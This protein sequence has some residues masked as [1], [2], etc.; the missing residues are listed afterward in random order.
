MLLLIEKMVDGVA[1]DWDRQHG[2]FFLT[3]QCLILLCAP[4]PVPHCQGATRS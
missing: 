3:F 1:R 4:I 2:L